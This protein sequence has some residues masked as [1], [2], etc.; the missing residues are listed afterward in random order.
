[1]L[2]PCL[3]LPPQGLV[4]KVLQDPH[5]ATQTAGNTHV[6]LVLVFGVGKYSAECVLVILCHLYRPLSQLI[7]HLSPP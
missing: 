7:A 5:T 6:R 2:R 1:M 4:F 3:C